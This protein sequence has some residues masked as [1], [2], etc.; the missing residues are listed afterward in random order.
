[1]RRYK[2][3]K[4][5]LSKIV[6]TS[7]TLETTWIKI[8]SPNNFFSDFKVGEIIHADIVVDIEL[9][10]SYIPIGDSTAI[11]DR[12]WTLGPPKEYWRRLHPLELLA[13]ASDD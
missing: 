9:E 3:T 2:I 11:W 4:E 1:M 10:R 5:H 7:Y 6:N 13:L 8:I 12:P